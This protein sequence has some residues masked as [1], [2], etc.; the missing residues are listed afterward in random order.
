[1]SKWKK[2]HNSKFI[3]SLSKSNHLSTCV[4]MPNIKNRL[5]NFTEILY[6]RFCSNILKKGNNS[7]I[8]GRWEKIW[9]CLFFISNPYVKFQGSSIHPSV[10]THTKRCYKTPEHTYNPMNMPKPIWTSNLFKVGEQKKTAFRNEHKFGFFLSIWKKDI[11][12]FFP[13]AQQSKKL[14]SLLSCSKRVN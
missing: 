7:K 12:F 4:S 11:G 8:I 14:M 10:F 13:N 1:M 6:T 9:A 2:G 5:N 3:L